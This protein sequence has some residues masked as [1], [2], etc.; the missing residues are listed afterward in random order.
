MKNNF[1]SIYNLLKYSA[2]NYPKKT[3][4]FTEK[5][6]INYGELLKSTNKIAA[7]L[8][9]NVKRGDN[10]GIFMDNSWEYIVA[11]YAISA[12]GATFVPINSALKS[13]ELSYILSD[14]DIKCIFCS[15]TLRD[16]AT[17]SIAIHQ[18]DTIIWVGNE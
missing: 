6:K 16:V 7:Y 11:T 15:E 17:K 14:A 2:I 9:Q 8:Q 1:N 3:A 12:V 4:I 13:K 10:I 18:C 5:G